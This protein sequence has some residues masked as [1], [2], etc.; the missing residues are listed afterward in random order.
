MKSG[1]I[2][3]VSSVATG[4]LCVAIATNGRSDNA[5]DARVFATLTLLLALIALG[6]L[7]AW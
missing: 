5:E 3:A 7:I 2:S 6:Q 1:F 4:L